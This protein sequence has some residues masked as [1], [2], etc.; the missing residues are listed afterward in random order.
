MSV[1][2]D[3]EHGIGTPEPRREEAGKEGE[4]P[5]LKEEE[6]ERCGWGD[7]SQ[8]GFILYVPIWGESEGSLF[9]FALDFVTKH[10]LI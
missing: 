5:K 7:G 2:Y 3:D 9:L 10:S 6:E 4:V 8:T 1:R